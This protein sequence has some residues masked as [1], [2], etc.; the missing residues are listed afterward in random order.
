[1]PPTPTL[2]RNTIRRET[3][4]QIHAAI[5]KYNPS[6]V[7]VNCA[8]TPTVA[9][10]VC[11]MG[12][13]AIVDGDDISTARLIVRAVNSHADLLEALRWYVEHDETNDSEDNKPFLEGKARAISAIDKATK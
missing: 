12:P 11:W 9:N 5:S 4:K 13:A 10:V 3:G 2:W 8:E 1:M 7:V 6:E